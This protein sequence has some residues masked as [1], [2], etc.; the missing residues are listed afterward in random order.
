[1]ALSSRARGV[2]VSG[3]RKVFALAG[4]LQ[5]PIDLSLGQPDFEA[6]PELCSKMK[7]A[8]DSGKNRY[9]PTQ[10]LPALRERIR[11]DYALPE[12][13]DV[14]ISSGVTGAL[15]LCYLSLLDIGDEVLIPDP[16]FVVYKELA[17]LLGVE[18]AYY[19][20][21]PDF[22]T[23]IDRIVAGCTPKTKAIVVNSPANPTGVAISGEELEAIESFARDRD[24]MLIYDEIYDAFSY[25]ATHPRCPLRENSVVVNGYS[26]TYGIPGWRVG[27]VIAPR[28]II[29]VMSTVQQYSY[30]CANSA[31]Q[32]ALSQLP[33]VDFSELRESYR[34]RRDFICDA[35]APKYQLVRPH[36]AFYVF[37]EAPGGDADAFLRR[38]LER[39]LLIVPGS[40]FSRRNT[41]FRISFSAP[42]EQLERGVEVLLD[43]A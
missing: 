37:P 3:I 30:V 32:V 4:S 8:I 9:L 1:M 13:F 22:Q 25:D 21:Y 12:E 17:S 2:D 31:A 28:E 24:I 43:L 27:F 20:T 15:A 41:H 26:K 16:Y 7:E 34:Q 5:N 36:G 39:E 29:A 14:C 40:A 35:L 23:T 42:M 11:N 33:E 19:D 10:G 6:F 38:C 18:I